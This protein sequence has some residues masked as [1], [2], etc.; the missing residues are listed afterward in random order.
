[1]RIVKKAPV[2]FLG[3]ILI[4]GMLVTVDVRADTKRN[5]KDIA[6]LYD[7]YDNNFIDD[8][9]VKDV[10]TKINE[11]G[12]FETKQVGEFLDSI[13]VYK[14]VDMQA[15]SILALTDGIEDVSGVTEKELTAT[16]TFYKKETT[17]Y[18]SV[19]GVGCMDE[20]SLGDVIRASCR[21]DEIFKIISTETVIAMD[22]T[23]DFL[24]MHINIYEDL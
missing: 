3:C 19:E 8:I 11:D 24:T 16:W 4:L 5:I 12:T 7:L 21:E 14:K 2:L 10:I 1:M 17:D 23:G 6:S 13:S 20:I 18:D 22:E 9:I 15:L